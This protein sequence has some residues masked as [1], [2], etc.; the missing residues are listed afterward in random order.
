M[1]A[2]VRD[3]RKVSADSIDA[4]GKRW[5]LIFCRLERFGLASAPI[6]MLR[7]P[8]ALRRTALCRQQAEH[9]PVERQVLESF[10]AADPGRRDFERQRQAAR[11]GDAD[12]DAGEGSRAYNNCDAR[13]VRE[14]CPTFPHQ[15]VDKRR[16]AGVV[17][18]LHRLGK[19]GDGPTVLDQRR[20]AGVSN[21]I[22]AQDKHVR[23]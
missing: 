12:A 22:D 4:G 5:Q 14:A 15:L 17:T 8:G 6:D 23:S 18:L 3:T 9:A 21:R 16:K 19:R 10:E 1:G 7:P 11:K 13:Q 2:G 20:F